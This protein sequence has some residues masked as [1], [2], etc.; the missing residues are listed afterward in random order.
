MPDPLQPD[1][2]PSRRRSPPTEPPTLADGPAA[3]GCGRRDSTPAADPLVGLCAELRRIHALAAEARLQLQRWP[4]GRRAAR[5]E[6]L[7]G[8]FDVAAQ[9]AAARAAEAARRRASPEP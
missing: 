6:Q 1:A 5:V 2:D 3:L 7:V 8:E 9:V 4:R